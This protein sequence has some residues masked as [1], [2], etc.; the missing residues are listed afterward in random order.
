VS[1]EKTRAPGEEPHHAL[2]A[3]EDRYIHS[4]IFERLVRGPEDIPGLVAY[5]IYQTRKREWLDEYKKERHHFPSLEEVRNYSFGW[6]DG[7]LESLRGEAEADMFR[8]AETVMK[9]KIDEMRGA[10]FN[11]RTI[12]EIDDLKKI[13]RQC[14]SYRHHIIGHVIGFVALVIV[15]A[16]V[17]FVLAHEP[18]I[19]EVAGWMFRPE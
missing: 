12:H 5:G 15:V 19:R 8:F 16:G 13:V 10:A 2:V 7:S 6:R 14:G 9:T 11:I 18:S 4:D 17:A 3:V 1:D